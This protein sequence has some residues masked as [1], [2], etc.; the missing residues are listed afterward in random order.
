MLCVSF[1]CCRLTFHS[2]EAGSHVAMTW[3]GVIQWSASSLQFGHASRARPAVRKLLLSQSRGTGCK[4]AVLLLEEQRLLNVTQYAYTG[5][6][7]L[8]LFTLKH[9]DYDSRVM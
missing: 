4:H 1:A 9:L 3:D 5:R 7:K 8:H 6:F 2:S